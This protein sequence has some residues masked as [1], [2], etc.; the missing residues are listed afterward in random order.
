MEEGRQGE[1]RRE[2]GRT[3]EGSVL[4]AAHGAK[5]AEAEPVHVALLDV[6][7]GVLERAV[8]LLE[9][10]A[11]ATPSSRSLSSSSPTP[12]ETPLATELGSLCGLPLPALLRLK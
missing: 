4:V 10:H 6:V 3:W 2:G 7:I 5:D 12:S 1:R 9:T 11:A 8:W